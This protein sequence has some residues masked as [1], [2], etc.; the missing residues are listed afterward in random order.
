MLNLYLATHRR[1]SILTIK[2]GLHTHTHEYMTHKHADMALGDRARLWMLNS[3]TYSTSKS[4]RS[5]ECIE[6]PQANCTSLRECRRKSS[7]HYRMAQ[8]SLP[9]YAI[10]DN[11]GKSKSHPAGLY[12]DPERPFASRLVWGTLR[13]Q[14]TGSGSC[15]LARRS[16]SFWG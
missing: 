14:T 2:W 12:S 4:C 9:E 16:N 3:K 15:G 5:S 13:Y 7:T 6:T 1:R 11:V 10:Y 8:V